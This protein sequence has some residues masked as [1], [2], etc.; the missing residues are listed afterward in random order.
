MNFL[1]IGPNVFNTSLTWYSVFVLTGAIITY[2][3]T[4]F[5][6][7]KD[8]ESKKCP[9]LILNTFLMAF[10]AG[11]V[12][13]RLWYVLSEWKYYSSDPISILKVWEGGLAIQGGVMLGAAVG[14]FYVYHTIRKCGLNLKTTKIMD[15]AIPNI[16]IAQ[17]IGRWGNFFNREVYGACVDNLYALKNWWLLPNW[18]V[19]YM[20]GGVISGLYIS[21]P[22]SKF[23]QP[24]F[25][26]EGILNFIGFIL[27]SIVIR[28]LFTRRVDGTLTGMYLIWYGSVRVCLEGLRNEEF[29]MR[30]GNISQ[31]ILTSIIFIIAGVGY[32]VYLYVDNYLKKQKTENKIDTKF[33]SKEENVE[34]K[35]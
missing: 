14:I 12:G 35:K 20:R 7:K 13:A 4:E 3:I 26:Y 1:K 34:A 19:E 18:L 33:E 17:V 32:I 11:L 2:V 10:P 9:D 29:I 25:L 23:A 8:P 16:L 21:C 6:Y 24:L 27:I 22:T 5:L 31:S 15:L 30:W 28:K